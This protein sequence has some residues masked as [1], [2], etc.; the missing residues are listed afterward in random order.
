MKM[1]KVAVWAGVLLATPVEAQVSLTTYWLIPPT[2]GCDGLWAFGPASAVMDTCPAST[3]NFAP[4]NCVDFPGGIPP[5][6]NTVGDT[7][8]VAICSLPCT[9]QVTTDTGI[10]MVCIAPVYTTAEAPAYSKSRLRIAPNPI[11]S[12][13]R[14]LVLDGLSVTHGTLAIKNATGQTLFAK[15]ISQLPMA[16]VLPDLASGVYLVEVTEASTRFTQILLKE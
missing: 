9:F 8:I 10:C 5:F 2:M 15:E 14:E 12:S 11:G 6:P 13:D 16:V 7:V 1:H 4:F 3:W